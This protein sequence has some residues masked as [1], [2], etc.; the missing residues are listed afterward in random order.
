MDLGFVALGGLK[1]RRKMH[2]GIRTVLMIVAPM[3]ALNAYAQISATGFTLS[4]DKPAAKWTEALPLG[5]GRI[6]AMVFGGTQDERLQI[7]EGTLWGGG[8]HDYAD[9]EAFSHL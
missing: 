9:P 4:Y 6:G 1:L 8:P 5:N 3:V 7:N 2:S